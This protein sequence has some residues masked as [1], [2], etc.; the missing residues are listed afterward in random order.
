MGFPFSFNALFPDTQ[1]REVSVICA[2]LTCG[3]LRSEI[4]DDKIDHPRLLLCR[5]SNRYLLVKLSHCRRQL[6]SI[7]PYRKI[8]RFCAADILVNLSN[9]RRQL[10]RLTAYRENERFCAAD[11]FV[12]GY[13]YSCTRIIIC[14]SFRTLY[15]K[16]S[17]LN[18]CY[19]QK[20]SNYF[21]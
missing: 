19:M 20:K 9:C 18:F 12:N 5:C 13:N 7:T 21:Q 6:L 11:N 16:F 14:M 1:E 17:I 2:I 3:A 8:E 4:Q 10:L 15:Y